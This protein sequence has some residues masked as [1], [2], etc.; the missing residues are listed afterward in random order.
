MRILTPAWVAF[1]AAMLSYAHTGTAQI[2]QLP[3]ADT[4]AGNFF[5]VAVA[6]D[7]VHALVGASGEHSCITDGGAAYLYEQDAQ[8]L[9]W[10][11]VARLIAKDCEERRFFG[12]S[13]AID[14]SRALVSA[15]SKKGVHSDPDVVYVF[16]RDSTGQWIQ[17]ATLSTGNAYPDGNTGT[18]VTLSGDMAI[19]TTWGDTST[20]THGGAAYIFSYDQETRRWSNTSR[21]T[22]SG[23]VRYGIFG[24]N[25]ALENNILAVPSSQYLQEGR[26]SLY[27]FDQKGDGSWEESARIDDIDDFFISADIHDQQLIVG[28]SRG[29]RGMS[30]RATIYSQDSTGA[31]VVSSELKPPTPYRFGAFGS[32]VSLEQDRAL[33]TGYDEQLKLDINIDRVV[34]VYSRNESTGEWEYQGIIDIG[35]VAFGS[36]IDLDGRVALIGSASASTPGAAYIVRIP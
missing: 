28:E 15:S 13:V 29:G 34:Y 2:D 24:G 36:A 17:S 33:V 10:R 22:G 7:G 6:L 5:G 21:F 19:L 4:T 16:D 11:E 1:C 23:G 30:G 31:W 26:G 3:H 14:G 27:L 20:G 32:L 35:A 9:R 25:A 12:R 8:T 18:E